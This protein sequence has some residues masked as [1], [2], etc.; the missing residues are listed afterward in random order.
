MTQELRSSFFRQS[1]A[2][3]QSVHREEH[4]EYSYSYEAPKE[5]PIF[6]KN[7]R[8]SN[9]PLLEGIDEEK[10]GSQ[11]EK[12]S[13]EN[14]AV[15]DNENDILFGK[16]VINGISQEFSTRFVKSKESEL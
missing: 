1:T 9:A 6:K 8:V 7:R 4:C 11:L 12:Q 3:R 16:A 15:R 2:E 5:S 14:I 10:Q 13:L